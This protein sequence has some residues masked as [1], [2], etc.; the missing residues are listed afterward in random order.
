MIEEGSLVEHID[1]Q[2]ISRLAQCEA[3]IARLKNVTRV[4]TTLG[5]AAMIGAATAFTGSRSSQVALAGDTL[6]VREIAVVDAQGV[7]RARLGGDLPDAVG[8]LGRS[9]PRG[10]KIAGLLIYDSRGRERGGYVTFD[11]EGTAALTLDSR[12]P[13]QQML[14]IEADSTPVEGV[15][16]RLWS[17]QSWAELH[18]GASG[19]GISAGRDGKVVFFEPPATD[20]ERGAY[21]RDL[22]TA[23]GQAPKQPSPD[24]VLAA[25]RAHRTEKECTLCLGKP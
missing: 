1:V 21:C 23:V 24:E 7:V 5:V 9:I 2:G 20:A 11:R 17:R 8:R 3:E 12:D 6:S 10:D 15:G 14:L 25:C 16:L 18:A 19:A 4:M 22:K 13:Y